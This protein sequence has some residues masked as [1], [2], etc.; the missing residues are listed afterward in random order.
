MLRRV[1]GYAIITGFAVLLILSS[2]SSRCN[3]PEATV[4]RWCSR[5]AHTQG[6][7]KAVPITLAHMA[8]EEGHKHETPGIVG[9][10]QDHE[11]PGPPGHGQDRVPDILVETPARVQA[12][13]ETDT[14][15]IA[16]AASNGNN[17]SRPHPHPHQ[18]PYP[19]PPS[20]GE[21]DLDSLWS[22]QQ[23]SEEIRG[24]GLFLTGGMDK[25]TYNRVVARDWIEIWP[26]GKPRDMSIDLTREYTFE[27]LEEFMVNLARH[28]G[29]LLHT[30]GQSVQ[31]RSIYS[32]TVD[33]GPS[34]IDG[35]SQPDK[36]KPALLY[37]GQVH[38]NEFA[39]GL[40]ILKQ[41]SELIEEAQADRYLGSLLARVR[42]EAIPILNPDSREKS[43]SERSTNRKSNAN[44]VDLN[45]NFPSV[46]AA[47]LLSGIQK[48]PFLASSPGL[49]FYAGPYLG[50]EPE[51]QAA[52]KWLK[53]HVPGAVCFLDYHQQGRGIFGVDGK[54]WSK[55][56]LAI[57][58]RQ[59]SDAIMSHLNRGT[60]ASR[61][62]PYIPLY[63]YA[64]GGFN[65]GGGTTTDYAISIAAG[66]QYS[67]KYGVWVLNVG[68]TDMPL[69]LF[70]TLDNYPD[71]IQP[72]PGLVALT[73]EICRTA[74]GLGNP[75]GYNTV[76][77]RLMHHEYYAYNY[78]TLLIFMAELALGLETVN[79]LKERPA[80]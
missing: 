71:H 61:N 38:G 74:D 55:S 54:P 37:I 72:N 63:S 66:F 8:L 58:H 29:V 36:D 16:T 69:S 18:D 42:F 40:Y 60:G 33:L 53:T 35:H 59:I 47:Q 5:S 52:M 50:S 45:R 67:P 10:D 7:K 75:L 22:I 28:E 17:E 24:H 68:D 51:T 14:T 2:V 9:K 44:G 23:I 70:R 11:S 6:G 21:E 49:E 13:E 77:R 15:L 1:E 46:N 30:I 79:Q 64:G 65:G 12:I 20:P 80:G 32:L 31:G 56:E 27:E 4:H 41:F 3:E 43:V 34:T 19:E 73:V 25:S 26:Q 62:T 48:T 76:A 78:D 39:G 57:N